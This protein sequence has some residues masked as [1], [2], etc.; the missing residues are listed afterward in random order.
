MNS[1][2]RRLAEASRRL[3]QHVDDHPVPDP[4]SPSGGNSLRGGLVVAAGTLLAVLLGVVLVVPSGGG[5]DDPASTLPGPYGILPLD[6]YS[7]WEYDATGVE[8]GAGEVRIE[9]DPVESGVAVLADGRTRWPV[10]LLEPWREPFSC[11]ELR[12]IELPAPDELTRPGEIV[13]GVVATCDGRELD[14]AVRVTWAGS[15]AVTVPAGEF[16]A[17]RVD[18]AVSGF[19]DPF[20][21]TVSLWIDPLVGVVR[22][23]AV[24]G[25]PG[26]ER[27]VR[28]ALVA[29][30]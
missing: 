28:S 21:V 11:T 25:P 5:V 4:P 29:V 8:P 19:V 24:G 22:H 26:P 13:G 7:S 14:G 16:D 30:S 10:T 6:R 9:V 27:E 12:S 17:V 18:V 1:T 2:E 23:D 3:H 20:P 15:D